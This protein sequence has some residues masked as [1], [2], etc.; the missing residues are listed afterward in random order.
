MFLLSPAARPLLALVLLGRRNAGK[1]SAANTILGRTEFEAGVTTSQAVKK[2]GWVDGTRVVVVD[3]PG[4]SMLGL[5]NAEQ[6]RQELLRS[7]MLTSVGFRAFLLVIPVDVFSKRDCQAVL[8]YLSI[9]GYEIWKHTMV[10]FTWGDELRGKSIEKHIKKSGK[11]LQKILEMCHFRY[12]VFDNYA[13]DSYYQ[14]SQLIHTVM[15]M[16]ETAGTGTNREA[17]FYS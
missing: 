16:C 17:F 14:V 7:E 9:L 15:Q 2:H 5:A 10:L 8:E 1:T 13:T 4:W 3:T 11:Y 12:H 6:V